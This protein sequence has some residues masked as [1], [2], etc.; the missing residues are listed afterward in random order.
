[1]LSTVVKILSRQHF[2]I[3]FLIFQ[4]VSFDISWKL[5]PW[6]TICM[7]CQSL[8]IGKNKKNIIKLFSAEFA[9]RVVKVN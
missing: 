8:F 4:K 2:E 3:F 6:G 1:M 7:I 5:S 9:Q